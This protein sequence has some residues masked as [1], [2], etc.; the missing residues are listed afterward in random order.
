MGRRDFAILK[1]P[2]RAIERMTK[3]GE[4]DVAADA[5][6]EPARQPEPYRSRWPTHFFWIAA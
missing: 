1:P 5:P 2:Q 6:C 4:R 3:N